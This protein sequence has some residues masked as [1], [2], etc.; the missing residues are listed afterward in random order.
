MR[1]GPSLYLLTSLLGPAAAVAQ[2]ARSGG[3]GMGGM[4]MPDKSGDAAH[5]A[6]A[7]NM[8]DGPHMRMTPMRPQ[9]VADSVRA[10]AIADT[11]RSALAKYA[12]PAAAER[13]GFK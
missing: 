2:G 10:M 6:M 7:G 3:G 4:A 5:E 8:L 13:D 9:T 1:L 11:L 12:D